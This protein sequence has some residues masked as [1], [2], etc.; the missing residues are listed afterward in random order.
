MKKQHALQIKQKDEFI[1][2]LNMNNKRKA[3]QGG[4]TERRIVTRASVRKLDLKSPSHR[5]VSPVPAAKKR[6]F[7]DIATANSPSIVALNARKTKTHI[8]PDATPSL[9]LQV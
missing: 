8:A 5:F 2:E 7:W 1:R 6:S 4:D 9:L 3:S